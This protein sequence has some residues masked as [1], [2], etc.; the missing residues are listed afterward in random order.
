MLSQ[1]L[2]EISGAPIYGEPTHWLRRTDTLATANRHIEPAFPKK[3]SGLV[4]ATNGL[5]PVNMGE[6]ESVVRA[7]CNRAVIKFEHSLLIAEGAACN[8]RLSLA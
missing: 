5:L 1:Q 4:K 2:S 8:G 6:L 3:T 7:D